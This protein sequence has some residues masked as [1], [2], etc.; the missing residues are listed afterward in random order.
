MPQRVRVFYD[1]QCGICQAWVSR[2]QRLDRR[3]RAE[4]LPLDP[5][6]VSRA[7]L[8]LEACTRQMHVV[9][10][11]GRI[12]AGW[13]AVAYLTRL[14]PA[15]WPIG[16]LGAVPPF[17]WLGRILYG[18]VAGNRYALSKCHGGACRVGKDAR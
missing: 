15:T 11:Q 6:L 10:S 2:L 7:G 13:N 5:E 3:H 8:D 17:R 18:W 1:D 16:A 9:T 14:F 12:L 4:C